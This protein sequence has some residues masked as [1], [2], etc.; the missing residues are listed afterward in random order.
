MSNTKTAKYTSSIKSFTQKHG[1]ILK[2]APIVIVNNQ[3]PNELRQPSLL[4]EVHSI[5]TYEVTSNIKG[6]S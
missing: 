6:Q 5:T 3:N 4:K 2:S 1:E